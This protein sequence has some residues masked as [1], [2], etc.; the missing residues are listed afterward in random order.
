MRYLIGSRAVLI[1]LCLWLLSS[2]LPATRSTQ[3]TSTQ[4]ETQTSPT[5][6]ENTT[7][8]IASAPIASAPSSGCGVAAPSTP[9]QS[10]N[11]NGVERSFILH[12]PPSYDPNRA[13]AL[14]FA[15]HGRTN[16]NAQAREYFGLESAFPDALI[17]YPSGLQLD[18]GFS[19]ANPGDPPENLRDFALFDELLRVTRHMYCVDSQR[20]YAV[21]HSL[22][23]YFAADL[24]CA[25]ASE[26]RAVA[27][28]G[29]GLQGSSCTNSVAAMVLHNP[30]DTLVPVSEGEKARDVFVRTLG[31][32]A[33]PVSEAEETL[34]AF[35]CSRYSGAA[36]AVLW[37]PHRFDHAYD[38]SYY[39]HTWP[40][41]TATAMASFFGSLP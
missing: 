27:L 2:C 23:G 12:V 30:N 39:P 20:V 10:V 17:L 11:V 28:L 33:S 37:C 40:P 6:P 32:V 26:L 22:G 15:F 35:G 9:L 7:A 29:A 13:H 18:T 19:W 16:S 14:V 5:Q 8:P 4:D 21:G 36:D 1:W 41:E 34:R 38:G 25:R 3:E 31:S 24:G